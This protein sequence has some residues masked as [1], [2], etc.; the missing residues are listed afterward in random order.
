MYSVLNGPNHKSSLLAQTRRMFYLCSHN[1]EQAGEAMDR[2]GQLRN[3]AFGGAWSEQIAGE[4]AL[5]AAMRRVEAAS[6]ETADADL[7]LDE[8]L[9]QAL[10]TVADAHPKG[11]MLQAAWDRA[12]ALPFATLRAGELARIARTLREGMSHRLND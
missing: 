10:S 9:R 5:R 6:V 7:R 3:V 8:T 4:E 2:K 11:A 12:L 1:P